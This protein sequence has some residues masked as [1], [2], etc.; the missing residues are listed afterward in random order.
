W[1]WE[2][3]SYE[4]GERRAFWMM[5]GWVPT[6]LG[7]WIPLDWKWFLHYKLLCLVLWYPNIFLG[8]F[9]VLY[10]GMEEVERWR[11]LTCPPSRTFIGRQ[12][13]NLM[14]GYGLAK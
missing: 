8:M 5:G 4:L 14:I 11:I 13:T 3:K 2:T 7:F 9:G 12:R 6:Y 1:W 10:I